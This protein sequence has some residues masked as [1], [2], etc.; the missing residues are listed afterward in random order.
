MKIDWHERVHNL[1]FSSLFENAEVIEL[2][3][4]SFSFN[5]D[6][7]F[8]KNNTVLENRREKVQWK[9]SIWLRCYRT[10]NRFRLLVSVHRIHFIIYLCTE[11]STSL[12]ASRLIS[13]RKCRMNAKK[14]TNFFFMVLSCTNRVNL[15]SRAE[16]S[17]IFKRV[18]AVIDA[19]VLRFLQ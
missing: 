14:K 1:N 16:D 2:D 4:F 12:F 10:M 17:V 8:A 18:L 5:S 19:W 9:K 11:K 3:H 6:F 13:Q 15:N 7:C